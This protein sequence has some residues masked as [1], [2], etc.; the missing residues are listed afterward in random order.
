MPAITDRSP[1]I[2]VVYDCRGGRVI[3]RFADAYAAR[4]F[5][6]AQLKAGRRPAVVNPNKENQMTTK[7]KKPRSKKPAAPAANGASKGRNYFAGQIIKKHGLDADITDALV[8][9]VDKLT[10]K[11]NPKESLFCLRNARHA[12]RGYLGL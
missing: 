3:K 2:A 5:Y 8:A 9:Q 6:V 10:G 1:P 7:A 11:P 12:I 4:R